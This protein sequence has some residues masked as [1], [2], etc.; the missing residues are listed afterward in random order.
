M[1]W[2]RKFLASIILAYDSIA[3]ISSVACICLFDK[4]IVSCLTECVMESPRKMRASE[5]E[6]VNQRHSSLPDQ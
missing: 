2:S 5:L 4:L 1:V 6:A 3:A